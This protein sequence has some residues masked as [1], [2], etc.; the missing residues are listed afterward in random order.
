MRII[1]SLACFVFVIVVFSTVI[2]ITHVVSKN[3]DKKQNTKHVSM[4]FHN[5]RFDD[6]EIE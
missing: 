5:Q 1:Y 4:L 3:K 6:Q 2:L